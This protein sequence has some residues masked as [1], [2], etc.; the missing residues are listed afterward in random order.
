[1]KQ[2]IA[3]GIILGLVLITFNL[4][5]AGPSITPNSET[6]HPTIDTTLNRM[7]DDALNVETVGTRDGVLHNHFLFHSLEPCLDKCQQTFESCMSSAG[8]NPSK[9]FRCKEQRTACTL[10]CDDQYYNQLRF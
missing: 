3:S 2:C 9:Q 7:I 10:N 6:S 8:D 5:F 4:A 1:M